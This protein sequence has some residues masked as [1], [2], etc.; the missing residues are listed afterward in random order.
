MIA[1]LLHALTYHLPGR[2]YVELPA[3]TPVDVVERE[4]QTREQRRLVD[5]FGVEREQR[6]RRGEEDVPPPEWLAVVRWD[7]APEGW[8]TAP[9]E[10]L[11]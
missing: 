8:T 7:E 1:R 4:E 9:R 11:G 5:R 2:G 3:G 10:A 6:R